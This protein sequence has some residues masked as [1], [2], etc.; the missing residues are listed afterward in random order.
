MNVVYEN[1]Y[2]NLR[3]TGSRDSTQGLFFDRDPSLL[4]HPEFST[5]LTVFDAAAT[6]KT[7][8]LIDADYWNVHMSQMPLHER[9]WVLQERLLARRV[10]H[11]CS[12]MLAWE[13]VETDAAETYPDG[14]PAFLDETPTAH[15]KNLNLS[16]V[17]KSLKGPDLG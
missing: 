9:G 10:L 6:M 17:G 11:F 1:A 14:L 3:A 13:C 12:H 5:A 16:F 4:R 2:C 15:F 8:A 7:F